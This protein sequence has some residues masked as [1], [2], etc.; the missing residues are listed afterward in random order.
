[1]KIVLAIDDSIYS[2]AAIGALAKFRPEGNEIR[3]LHVLQPVAVSAP[4]QMSAG[5]A[6][7][8][9]GQTKEAEQFVARVADKLRKSGFQT[10]TSV[11]QGD[12]RQSIVD[13][14]KSWPADLIV[15]GSRG[16]S[17]VSNLLLGSA[18]ESVARHAP[19]SVLIARAS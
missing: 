2:E 4:P 13:V 15:M 7:E 10:E 16:R 6:P 11:V 3:V 18:A 9:A 12:I 8:L 14:A 17:A 1:M 19:C 5:Y